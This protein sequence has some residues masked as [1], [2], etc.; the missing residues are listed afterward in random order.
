[1]HK[2]TPVLGNNFTITS[3]QPA[4]QG[5]LAPSPSNDPSRS[6]NNFSHKLSFFFIH[7]TV[8]I[9]LSIS[10]P[11]L[12]LKKCAKYCRI[13]LDSIISTVEISSMPNW[14]HTLQ[15]LQTIIDYV[16]I[17]KKVICEANEVL[18]VLN[19]NREHQKSIPKSRSKRGSKEAEADRT[20]VFSTQSLAYQTA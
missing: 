17:N 16:N 14:L 8:T 15:H 5:Y 4:I 1:M 3:A 9:C 10:G 13:S 12:Y 2:N 20:T 18:P 7:H 19:T 6:Q 11:K